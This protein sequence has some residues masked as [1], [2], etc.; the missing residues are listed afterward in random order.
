MNKDVHECVV[1][2]GLELGLVLKHLFEF[3]A[4]DGAF[5]VSAFQLLIAPVLLGLGLLVFHLL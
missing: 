2:A 4:V 1:V 3:V 5:F